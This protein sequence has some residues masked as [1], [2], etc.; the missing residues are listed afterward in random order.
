MTSL[1]EEPVAGDKP[2]CDPAAGAWLAEVAAILW[3][4]HLRLPS[5]LSRYEADDLIQDLFLDLAT[6]SRPAPANLTAYLQRALQFKFRT[7]LRRRRAERLCQLEECAAIGYVED[8][9]EILEPEPEVEVDE[10]LSGFRCFVVSV[11]GSAADLPSVLEGLLAK[12][13]KGALLAEL[14][15]S[16]STL[17][18]R[19]T[20]IREYCKA[21]FEQSSSARTSARNPRLV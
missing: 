17:T 18:R 7:R 8:P 20:V 21:Y 13:P 19:R 5:G 9:I 3:S 12:K 2:V 16:R 15:T 11:G 4:D 6:G 14:G 10:L 1:A